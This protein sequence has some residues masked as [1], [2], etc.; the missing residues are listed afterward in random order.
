V[1]DIIVVLYAMV[2]VGITINEIYIQQLNLFLHNIYENPTKIIFHSSIICVLVI[3]GTRLAC[4]RDLEDMITVLGI[5]AMTTYFLY[6]GRGFR[7]ICIYVNIFHFII[8]R[9]FYRFIIIYSIFIVGFAECKNKFCF[10][11]FF[12]LNSKWEISYFKHSI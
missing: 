11:L 12:I 9:D 4:L 5:I 10:E 8:R 3:F 6:F 7:Q 1:I 2:F